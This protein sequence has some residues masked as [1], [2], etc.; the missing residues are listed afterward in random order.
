MDKLKRE[1]RKPTR[2]E[3]DRITSRR[4]VVRRIPNRTPKPEPDEEKLEKIAGEVLNARLED[5]DQYLRE[6][7]DEESEA[8]RIGESVRESWS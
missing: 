4:P 3:W 6:R 8:R 7:R 1:N 2:A 5:E